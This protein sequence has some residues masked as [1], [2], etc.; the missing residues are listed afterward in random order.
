[1]AK[2]ISTNNKTKVVIH[3]QRYL[4]RCKTFLK[5]SDG[6][7]WA[8]KV[9]SEME[10]FLPTKIIFITKNG[11][12]VLFY[13]ELWWFRLYQPAGTYQFLPSTYSL[14]PNGYRYRVYNGYG[15]YR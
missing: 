14:D 10:I 3:K 2:Y 7:I 5:K 11:V 1:M 13:F 12:I 15:L 8:R 9:D 6:I 4:S